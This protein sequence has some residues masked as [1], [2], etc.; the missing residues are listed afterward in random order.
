[1]P[2]IGLRLGQLDKVNMSIQFPRSFS[3]NIPLG[4]YVRTSIF[5]KPQ[6]GL[7]AFANTDS[8]K[9]GDITNND[10]LYFGRNE[11]LSGWRVDV[12]PTKFLNFYLSSGLTTSN[13]IS[14]TAPATAKNSTSPYKDYYRQKIKPSIFIN[15]GLTLRFGKTKSIYNNYQLYNAIDMNNGIDSGDNG[16]N[17]GNGNVPVLPKKININN[18]DEVLDLIEAQDLY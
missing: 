16:V 17:P 10:K 3:L 12:L 8:L 7:F 6:G 5:A 13:I 11:F 1:M 9:I 18:P 15:F 4:K 2:Y 14:F